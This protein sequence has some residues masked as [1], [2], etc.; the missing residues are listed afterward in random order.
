MLIE[1]STLVPW[2]P[3]RCWSF[4]VRPRHGRI[5]ACRPWT[6]WLRLSFVLTCTVSSQLRSASNVSCGVGRGEHEVAA[7]ADEDLHVA[8][9]HAPRSCRTVSSPCSRGGSMPQT[10]ASRSRN[11][12]VGRW[13]TP[14]VR[15]PWTFECPRIG[16]GPAPVAADVAAQQQQVDD[17]ADRVDAVLLLGEAEAP[18]DDRAV[19]AAVDLRDSPDRRLVDARTGA[20][21]RPTASPR[22]ARGSPRSRSCSA[23][24]NSR[25]IAFGSVSAASSTALATPRRSA[26]SPPMRGWTFSVPVLRGVEGRHRR[27][28]V[29]DDRAPRRPPR[30]SGSRARPARRARTPRPARSASAARS[31]RR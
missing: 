23:S 16:D 5:S 19:G 9:V 11:C 3:P 31:R 10:S 7:H 25:S 22:R 21:A 24:R 30:P 26:R 6:R 27:E 4:S 14:Q 29:R 15:L 28:V 2:R 17:L 12:A 8:A 1:S 18:G 13:L 20:R